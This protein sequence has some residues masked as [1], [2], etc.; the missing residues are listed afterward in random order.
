MVD[1]KPYDVTAPDSWDAARQVV[2]AATAEIPLASWLRVLQVGVGTGQ[3]SLPYLEAGAQVIGLDSSFEVL[4]ALRRKESRFHLLRQFDFNEGKA[5]PDAGVREGT[6]QV[7]LMCDVSGVANLPQESA[8]V[9]RV[10]SRLL[11]PGGVIT[12]V[13][14]SEISERSPTETTLGALLPSLG[15]TL[16]TSERFRTDAD[17]DKEGASRENPVYVTL[18]TA[19]MTGPLRQPP[20]ALQRLDR[21]ACVDRARVDQVAMASL[22]EG[23]LTPTLSRDPDP[24]DRQCEDFQNAV[25]TDLARNSKTL[26]VT[27]PWPQVTGEFIPKKIA[28]HEALALF[29]HPDDEAIYAG[30]TLKAFTHPSPGCLAV[31]L[32]T[33][34][35]G[36]RNAGNGTLEFLR[37]E[38]S[39][40]AA[41]RMG[42][43]KTSFLG[44]SDHGKYSDKNRSI[45]LTPWETLTRWG[46]EHSLAL[47]VDAIRRTRPRSLLS[48]EWSHDPN[49]SLHAHHL[50]LGALALIAF[51]QAANPEFRGSKLPPWAVQFHYAV[52]SPDRSGPRSFRIPVDAAWKI[53]LIELYASQSFSTEKLLQSLRAGEP[54]VMREVWWLVQARE[55]SA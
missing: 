49:Y 19:R 24:I 51:H 42:L 25:L 33:A 53:S 45:P 41:E 27:L 8:A 35:E 17:D 16:K 5:L 55:S 29:A 10:L 44:L 2:R 36:G 22:I 1:Q 23:P 31:A 54:H 18:L 40:R 4:D 30:C 13:M 21:T 12:F 48:F 32:A 37:G 46:A 20:A 14:N 50:A 6:F 26:P 34:G 43:L 39:A 28:S 38:E 7:I 52:V 15:L 3:A 9:L 47:T 11:V